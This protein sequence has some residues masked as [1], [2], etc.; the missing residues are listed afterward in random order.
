MILLLATAV[1]AAILG[2]AL[3]MW[4]E[5]KKSERIMQPRGHSAALRKAN[6]VR[7]LNAPFQV[8]GTTD[9]ETITDQHGTTYPL[10]HGLGFNDTKLGMQLWVLADGEGGTIARFKLFTWWAPAD[11]SY[12]GSWRREHFSSGITGIE[13][14][15]QFP[16]KYETPRPY[17]D[18]VEPEELLAAAST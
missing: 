7:W 10:V 6:R 8:V 4:I 13:V 15:S 9:G 14:L 18:E 3:G 17:F 2:T 12:L 11:V 5:H 1:A 16:E